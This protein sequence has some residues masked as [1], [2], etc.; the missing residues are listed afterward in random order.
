[1]QFYSPLLTSDGSKVSRVY[2]VAREMEAYSTNYI[3]EKTETHTVAF[4]TFL[5]NNK[6]FSYFVYTD[7]KCVHRE[8]II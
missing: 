4:S 2:V 6:T 1:M 7:L 8:C 3:S 5:G